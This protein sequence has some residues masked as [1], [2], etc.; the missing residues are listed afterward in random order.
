MDGW[1][2]RLRIPLTACEQLDLFDYWKPRLRAEWSELRT[3]ERWRR[4]LE[5]IRGHDV[6]LY[7]YWTDYSGCDGCQ[8]FEQGWCR[9]Q[10]LPASYNPILTPRLGGMIGMACMG[11]RPDD[12]DA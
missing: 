11:M 10:G 9:L 8:H 1:P 5:L 2:E 6:W 7:E 4:W 3:P 12:C